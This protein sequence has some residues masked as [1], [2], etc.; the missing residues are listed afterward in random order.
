MHI[1]H[2]IVLLCLQH[3]LYFAASATK[4]PQSMFQSYYRDNK[5][6]YRQSFCIQIIYIYTNMRVCVCTSICEHIVIWYTSRCMG[7]HDGWHA[8]LQW[9]SLHSTQ[10]SRC[11]IRSIFNQHIWINEIQTKLLPICL[12]VIPSASHVAHSG[13]P[14]GRQGPRT[15]M[16]L[17][18]DEALKA[19]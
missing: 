6:K 9:L 19:M 8:V 14:S 3:G 10:T 7:L 2:H 1:C 15:E 16:T 5:C 11:Y 13:S 12:W 18:D 17:G 4:S